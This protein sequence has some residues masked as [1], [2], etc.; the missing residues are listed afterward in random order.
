MKIDCIDGYGAVAE[1][2]ELPLDIREDITVDPHVLV[3]FRE[4]D[5]LAVAER[6]RMRIKR[7]DHR[8]IDNL[9]VRRP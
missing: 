7:H 8:P 1:Q 4:A 2:P 6:E 9:P 5:L 3:L